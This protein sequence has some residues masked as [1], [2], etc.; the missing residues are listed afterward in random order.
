MKDRVRDAVKSSRADYTEIRIERSWSSTV[1]L[2]G[3]LLEGATAAV[4]EGG[5]VRCLTMGHGWGV[6]SF[7][8]LDQ[9][10]D[11]VVRAHDLSLAVTLDDPIPWASVPV[12][13]ADVVMDLD[14]DFRGVP[15]DAKHAHAARLNEIMMDCD[16]RIVSTKVAYRDEVIETWYA[17]SEGTS[18]HTL[19]PEFTISAA[20]VAREH[21]TEERV[22]ASIGRRRGWDT[23]Q[24]HDGLFRDAA[25]RA[26][27]LLGVDWVSEG[28]Y[29]VIL[30][31]GLAGIMAHEAIGHLLEADARLDQT[32]QA[33]LLTQGRTVGPESLT[34]GDDGSAPGLR[35]SLP[36][37]DE[38]TPTGNTTLIQNGVVVGRLHSRETAARFDELPT[39]NARAVSYRYPPIVR[40]TNTYLSPGEDSLEDLLAGV[41]LGVYAAD[42][43][44]GW[45]RSGRF[46]FT[47]GRGRMIRHGELAEEV[48]DV[49][50]SGGLLETLG[51][52]DGIAGDFRWNESG[53]GCDKRGQGP[54][55]VSD[56]APHIRVASLTVGRSAP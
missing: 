44:S 48:K 17:N 20:A 46:G 36:F 18:F 16:R 50:I 49:T 5:C 39:G 34:V 38:G 14:G 6:V 8:S 24:G 26:V 19:R 9:L 56:G 32:G 10:R 3:D 29:P 1:A 35:G 31:P 2:R 53:G 40:L 13:E 22:L 45:T 41:E 7:T 12:R 42:A 52:L 37:D 33:G 51:R 47:A 27:R 28:E 25:E 4:D 55:P 11:M 30:D 21:G 23:A 54:L 15:L 43:V